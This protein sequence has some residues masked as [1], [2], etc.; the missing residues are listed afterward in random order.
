[1][2][3]PYLRQAG[4]LVAVRYFLIDEAVAEVVSTK[5]IKVMNTSTNT[6]TSTQK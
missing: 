3:F 2:E 4:V 5:E 1:M 6:V